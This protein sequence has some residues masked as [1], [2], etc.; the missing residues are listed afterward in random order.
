MPERQLIERVRAL[1]QLTDRMLQARQEAKNKAIEHPEKLTRIAL[2]ERQTENLRKTREEFAERLVRE[3]SRHAAPLSAWISAERL[4]LD[5]QLNRNL[6]QSAEFCWKA[7]DAKPPQS[8][9][10]RTNRLASG[11]SWIM[12]CGIAAW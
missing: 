2:A 4:Y 11:R 7:L 6:E 1:H 5:V 12:P 10:M 3:E 9:K 8:V